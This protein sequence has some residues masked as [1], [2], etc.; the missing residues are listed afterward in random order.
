MLKRLSDL[1][2]GSRFVLGI[3]LALMLVGILL[4][5]LLWNAWQSAAT[6][7]TEAKLSTNQTAAALESGAD[8]VETV[9]SVHAAEVII[10]VTTREN[11]RAIRT[12]PGA[13]APVD[14]ELHATGLRALCARAAYR[15]SEQCLQHADPE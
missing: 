13:A 7:K 12:A 8:A 6:A 5:V 11:E 2:T 10:D 1:T 3:G 9:G 15:G 14:P 4:A